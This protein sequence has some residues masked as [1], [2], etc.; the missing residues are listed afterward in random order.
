MFVQHIVQSE[1]TGGGLSPR[2]LTQSRLN[3]F[4]TTG[5]EGRGLDVGDEFQ[6]GGDVGIAKKTEGFAGYLSDATQKA[7]ESS[8]NTAT[9]S[10]G[11]TARI[12]PAAGR[13]RLH[14]MLDKHRAAER[15]RRNRRRQDGA[16]VDVSAL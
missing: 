2:P 15:T 6:A 4:A 11:G 14:D 8:P 7:H 12:R 9:P 5:K 10:Q 1:T 3:E 16:T 13:L